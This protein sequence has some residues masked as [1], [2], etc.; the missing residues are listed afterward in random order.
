MNS[1]FGVA[2]HALVY[3]NHKGALV[4]SEALA[5]NIC[6]NPARVRKIMAKLKKAGLVFTREGLEGGYSFQK[7]PQ[8]VTL[9]DVAQALDCRFVASSWR[10]GNTDLPC[11]IASGMAGVLDGIYEELD[12][13]CKETLAKITIADIDGRIF[14]KEEKEEV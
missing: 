4:S 3:L 9:Y 6:T 10:S 12:K 11:L 13:G 2:V 8:C 5:G 14:K 1:E 7:E